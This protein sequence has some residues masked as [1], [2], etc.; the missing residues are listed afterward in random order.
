MLGLMENDLELYGRYKAKVKLET[1]RRFS[2]RNNSSLILCVG[3]DADPA[4]EGKTTVSIG[5]AQALAKNRKST[6]AALREPST[7]AC[8]PA[9]KAGLPAADFPGVHSGR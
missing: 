2:R 3:H 4:G 5:L 7:R 6:I 9:S 8:F 1:I